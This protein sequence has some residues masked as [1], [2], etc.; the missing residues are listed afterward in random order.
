MTNFK[1]EKKG[2]L[3]EISNSKISKTLSTLLVVTMIFQTAFPSIASARSERESRPV[4]P[5]PPPVGESCFK[6]QFQQPRRMENHKRD[7]LFVID[8]SPQSA[9]FREDMSNRLGHF[10]KS[11]GSLDNLRIAVLLEKEDNVKMSGMLF[12][13]KNEPV[14]LDSSTS[15]QNDLLQDLTLKLTSVSQRMADDQNSDCDSERWFSLNDAIGSQ[16]PF[17]RIQGFFRTDTPLSI[18]F[19]GEKAKFYSAI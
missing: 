9:D 6:D 18:V 3:S 19:L 17:N 2:F 11:L 5:L 13:A 16:L 8:G 7:L 12:R 10:F 4:F 14:V 1:T 15:S